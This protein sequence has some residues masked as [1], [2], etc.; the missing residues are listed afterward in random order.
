MPILNRFANSGGLWYGRETDI[1]TPMTDAVNGQIK[2]LFWNDP[3][4]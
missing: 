1:G 3:E 2:R 4:E